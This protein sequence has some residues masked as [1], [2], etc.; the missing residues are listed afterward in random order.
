MGN[1]KIDVFNKRGEN[2]KSKFIS[3][4]VMAKRL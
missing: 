4:W 1:R 2:E 3:Q